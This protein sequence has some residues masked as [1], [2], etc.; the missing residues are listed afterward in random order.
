[1]WR[2]LSAEPAQ[3]RLRKIKGLKIQLFS[4]QRQNNRV[5]TSSPSKSS[6]EPIVHD[7]YVI[8]DMLKLRL[9][10]GEDSSTFPVLL[11]S[12]PTT[13]QSHQTLGPSIYLPSQNC[14]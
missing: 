7:L 3:I 14:E 8:E 6:I 4:H 2:R 5:R 9:L 10:S 12:P 13:S 11:V 1:M